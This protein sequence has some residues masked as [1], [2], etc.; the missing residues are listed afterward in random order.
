MSNPNDRSKIEKLKQKLI[1]SVLEEPDFTHLL[2]EVVREIN[3]IAKTAENE[4]TLVS[5]FEIKLY[6]LL[7]QFGFRFLPKKEVIVDRILHVEKGRADSKIGAV[8]IEYKHSSKLNTSTDV[9]KAIE[10][11]RD[12]LRTFSQTDPVQY[13]GFLTDGLR[14]VEVIY[15][16]GKIASESSLVDFTYVEALRLIRNIVASDKTRLTPENLIKDFCSTTDETNIAFTMAKSLYSILKSNPSK[17]TRMLRTEW[18]QL[19]RLGHNDKSQQQRIQDREEALEKIIGKKFEQETSDDQYAALFALQTT[20]AILVKFIAYRIISEVKFKKALKSY[21]AWLKA[22]PQILRIFCESLENGDIFKKL[23]ILNLL[24]G[25]FFSWYSA[26]TQWN[27]EIATNVKKI[28][29]TLARYE[30]ATEIFRSDKVVDLFKEL[31]ESIMPQVVRSSLGEFYTPEWLADHVLRSVKPSTNNWRGLDPC[32]GSGT[33]VIAMI[34]AALEEMHDKPQK[35]QLHEILS[36][37]QAIDLNP[38]AVLTTRIN[39][40]IRIAHLIPKEENLSLQIPVYLGDASYVPQ[41]EKI[42]GV[43]CIIYSIKTI[44]RPIEIAIPQE[45]VSN[46]Q[47]FSQIMSEY[48]RLIRAKDANRAL[49]V[50]TS[51]LSTS[52]RKPA[53]LARLKTLTIDLIELEKK[54][55]NGIWARIITNFLSTSN[56]GKFEIIIG[57]PPWIDWKNLPAGYRERIKGLCINKQIFSGDGRTGGINLNVCALITSVAMDNWLSD[58]GKLAFLMPKMIAFQQSYDGFRQFRSGTVRRR[59]L[60]FTIGLRLET[61]SLQFKRNS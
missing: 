23:G 39:Y 3:N 31:Y 59:F 16:G 36:R 42:D 18:E 20:Y 43:P 37:V 8:V 22:E 44:D 47:L 34:S 25:D 49:R 46:L 28:L 30:N 13:Y 40:F 5:G 48:E 41:I 54:E 12:Y 7:S 27:N 26:K 21:H 38:L 29:E 9:E 17:K 1:T 33:F 50:L 52:A 11:L 53:V 14:C 58:T 35:T 55:W 61:L 51:K 45:L 6:A 4:P 60:N 19:F 2:K 24:E 57:N 15:E 10:Q 32:A 56:L